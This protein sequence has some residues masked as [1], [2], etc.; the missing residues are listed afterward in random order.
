VGVR[1]RV[2]TGSGLLAQRIDDAMEPRVLVRTREEGRHVHRFIAP[3]VGLERKG[4]Q[5]VH[6]RTQ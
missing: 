5:R 3:D 2:V 4:T 1:V 6:L